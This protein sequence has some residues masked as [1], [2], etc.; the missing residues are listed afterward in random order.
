MAKS[1]FNII[2]KSTDSAVISIDGT[3]GGW[4]WDSWDRVNTGRLIRRQLKELG[5][6]SNIE[7]RICS[8]GG[9]VDEAL[10]IHDALKDHSAT[11]TTII[12]G[13][14]ASAA[15]I[16][17]LAGDVRKISKNS[18]YLI[19]KCSSLASGNEH[20]LQ[21]ELDSQK[22][23]NDILYNMYKEVCKKSDEELTE[24]FDAD[25]GHG[26][27]IKPEEAVDFGF[28]TEVYNE[29]QPSA[30]VAMADAETLAKL[31]YPS[32]PDGTPMQV[33]DVVSEH[34]ERLIR[35]IIDKARELFAPKTQVEPFIINQNQP[36]MKKF[37]AVFAYLGALLAIKDDQEYDDQAGHTLSNEELG[38][39]EAELAA[40]AQLKHDHQTLTAERDQLKKDNETL[41][42]ERDSY[43]AKWEAKPQD[44]TNVSGKDPVDDITDN[45]GYDRLEKMI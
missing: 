25:N 13:F 41:T 34:E 43:K 7:V 8:L 29:S 26:R 44:V 11:V 10:Q 37:L 33:D 38:K 5:D 3:I 39:V 15:T 35:R 32:L 21:M 16:I 12:N 20:D 31:N 24:L 45:A 2:N 22:T 36:A 14:C 42:S 17:A 28:C 27:W 40:Y 4:D 6:V 18:V 19:H 1:F 23:V 9:D 30:K